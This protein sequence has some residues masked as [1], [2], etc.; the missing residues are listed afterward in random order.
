MPSSTA[1]IDI[2]HMPVP[3]G[4]PPPGSCVRLEREQDGRL[5]RLRLDPP[6]RSSPVFDAALLRDLARALA[7]VERDATA[8]G[9]VICGREPLVFCYGADVDSIAELETAEQARRVGRAGQE[10]FERLHRLGHRAGGRLVTVAAVGGPVP[11]GA[12][13]LC[14]AC[15][16]VVLAEDEKSRIGLPEVML[17]IV[18]GWGGCQR[19][20]RRV[21]VPK[22]LQ[23]I[24]SGKL[25]APRPA[26]KLGLVDR[27]THPQFLGRVAGEIALGAQRLEPRRR[28]L[29][30]YLIDRNP[31]ALALIGARARRGVQEQTRGHYPAP[32]RALELVLAAPGT[33]LAQG[34]EREARVLGDLAVSQESRALVAI[35]RAGERSKQRARGAGGE[36]AARFERAAVVGAG[37]MGAEIASLFAT[38]RLSTR[39]KDLSQAQLDAAQVAHERRVD[40]ARQR[41]R[42][43]PHQADAALDRLELTRTDLG[44]G[45]CDLV[46]E[47]IAEVLAV[48]RQVLT[49]LAGRVRPDA[50]LATNTSSL[51]VDALAAELPRPERVVGLHFFNPVS[52][53]PLVE[54]IRGRRTEP[55]VLRRA[56]QLAVDL[57]KTPVVCNDG[58]GFVVNRLLAPYL[59]EAMRLYETGSAPAELDRLALR[60]GLPMGPFALLDKVGLDIAAHTAQSLERALG[61]RLRA[62]TLLQPLLA[63]HELGEKTGLGIFVHRRRGKLRPGELN[64]RLRRPAEAP[65]FSPL[66]DDDRTD[67]LV[68]PMVNEAARLLAE[69]VV[70]SAA[71]LDLATVY[72]MGFPP[73]RGGVLR[74]AD[75]RGLPAV[76]ERLRNLAE[77]LEVQH[78]PGGPERFEP[79]PLLVELA[80][81]RGSFHGSVPAAS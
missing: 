31:L 67:R 47:A 68:L 15:D 35:F 29:W 51:S 18:P 73:F 37:V 8:R 54:V 16:H 10:I 3:A 80:A 70:E 57:G 43:Q 77:S 22:A 9:L 40:R 66:S 23:A 46:L 72:G 63:A 30:A 58:P 61:P 41:R 33:P 19:L 4:A 38:K 76:V 56:V 12:Y 45:Q 74:Y 32:L 27:L 20:P 34:L 78:R 53:L 44:F 64:P 25:Y 79:A 5:V 13:E 2:D 60:F 26:L 55:E 71:D 81:A 39:L 11:G 28:G 14:L 6:H 59:D 1:E 52:K 49:D 69:G 62:T 42:L 21:G 65:A 17:G 75:R 24:L 7:E 36:R 48:K 50:V